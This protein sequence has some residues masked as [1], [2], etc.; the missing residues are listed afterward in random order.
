MSRPPLPSSTLPDSQLWPVPEARSV[1]NQLDKLDKRELAQVSAQLEDGDRPVTGP[2]QVRTDAWT[3]HTSLTQRFDDLTGA[4]ES[5]AHRVQMNTELGSL[6]PKASI[7]AIQ[8]EPGKGAWI[9]SAKPTLPTLAHYIQ[10]AK[11]H[12]DRPAV[13][14][15]LRHYASAVM[16]V[17]RLILRHR[18]PLRVTPE[19][20]GVQDGRIVYIEHFDGRVGE[21]TELLNLASLLLGE[22]ELHRN[23]AAAVSAYV[24]TL[25]HAIRKQ[26]HAD[27]VRQLDLVHQFSSTQARSTTA[28]IARR[29]LLRAARSCGSTTRPS[30]PMQR[31]G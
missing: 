16:T 11:D 19:A 5:M 18:Y 17:V 22:V 27:E 30:P 13:T 25:D 23:W 24:N 10:H 14:H 9:W 4:H 31:L 28:D 7:L 29:R 15:A 8:E 26:L 3:L 12:T 21:P 20:F 6:L 2:W 1:L